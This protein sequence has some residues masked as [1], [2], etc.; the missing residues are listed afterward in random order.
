[1]LIDAKA[2]PAKLRDGGW[3]A[4]VLLD[5]TADRETVA[6]EIVDKP[7]TIETRA[8]KTWGAIIDDVVWVGREQDGQIPC[9]V[10]TRRSRGRGSELPGNVDRASGA[11]TGQHVEPV[12]ARD[13]AGARTPAGPPLPREASPPG[14]DD[15]PPPTEA[16]DGPGE[17][18]PPF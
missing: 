7:I 10:R 1:M 18:E 9:L 4:R 3:G 13:E 5:R 2:R 12:L 6:A 14:F 15:V 17:D 8:G 16:P 11:D